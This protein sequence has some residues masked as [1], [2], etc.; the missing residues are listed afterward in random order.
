MTRPG[1]RRSMPHGIVAL[2]LC[3]VALVS[4][5]ALVP[6]AVVADTPGGQSSSY[7]VPPRDVNSCILWSPLFAND[8]RTSTVVLT[9]DADSTTRV[10]ARVRRLGGG[11]LVERIFD[12]AAR[13]QRMLTPADL[14]VPSSFTGSIQLLVESRVAGLTPTAT[15]SPT[16]TPIPTST[17]L[18][19]TPLPTAI[20]TATAIATAVVTPASCGIHG[21]VLHDGSGDRTA[22]EMFRQNDPQEDVFIPA[23]HNNDNGFNTEVLIQNTNRDSDMSARLTFR[24]DGG[25]AQVERSINIRADSSASVDMTAAPQGASTLEIDGPT[26]ARLLATAI[27]S[28]P[29]GMATAINGIARGSSQVSLPLLFRRAGNENA[30]SSMIRVMKIRP[31]GVTPKATFWDRDSD[32]Q[33]GPVTARRADGSDVVLR[34]DEGFFW[35]LNQISQLQDGHYYSARV[36]SDERGEIGVIAAHLNM[37]RSTIAG[38]SGISETSTDRVLLIPYVVKGQDNVN[39]GI[40]LRNHS[41]S[42]A[43]VTIRFFTNATRVHTEALTVPSFDSRTVYLPAVAELPNG[44]YWADV[45]SSSAIAAVVNI[46]RYR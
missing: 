45:T 20:P 30:Y 41:G 40:Q 38:Y 31:G 27:H 28:G 13:Q 22:V 6:V 16:S 5:V 4:A 37:S 1:L 32:T 11:T 43:S 33:I 42:D 35:D 15:L 25:G 12:M 39:S 8:T 21:V 14:G 23:V 24:P 26:N 10:T 9:H 2:S 19:G 17:V 46:V 36:D 44:E 18:P 34:E 29:G 7:T 3:S